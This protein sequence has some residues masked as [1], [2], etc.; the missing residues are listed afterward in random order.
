MQATLAQKIHLI[1]RRAFTP[2]S[3]ARWNGPRPARRAAT[4]AVAATARAV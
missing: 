1:A 4:G 3:A 2:R